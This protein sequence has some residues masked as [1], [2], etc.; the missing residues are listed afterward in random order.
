M[1]MNYN[2]IKRELYFKINDVLTA[3]NGKPVRLSQLHLLAKTLYGL[4]ETSVNKY[5]QNLEEE[6]FVKYVGESG[7]EIVAIARLPL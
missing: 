1:I 5:I 4:G 3:S 6:G 2:K 7:D